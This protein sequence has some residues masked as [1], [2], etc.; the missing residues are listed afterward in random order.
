MLDSFLPI[1]SYSN[2]KPLKNLQNELVVTRLS[3][4]FS[5]IPVKAKLGSNLVFVILHQIDTAN[6]IR[7]N[8]QNDETHTSSGTCLMDPKTITQQ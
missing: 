5:A 2:F 3:I 8:D 1:E 4:K 6:V 7:V